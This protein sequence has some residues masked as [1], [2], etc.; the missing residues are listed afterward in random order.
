MRN[1]IIDQ[2]LLWLVLFISFVTMFLMVID[3]YLVLK[4]K[5]RCDTLAN[6]GVR[7]KALGR[8]DETIVIGLNNIKNSYFETI[9]IDDLHCEED[10][11]DID[12]QIVFEIT[13]TFNNM[14]LSNGEL[15]KSKTASFNEV[16]DSHIECSLILRVQ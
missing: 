2:I 1:A 12:Y 3:Y 16:S 9:T 11:E 13:T 5:D 14:F 8:D 15:I 6:Y 10:S 7:M 4:T